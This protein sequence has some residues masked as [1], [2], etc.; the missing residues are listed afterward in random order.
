M[1]DF[2]KFLRVQWDRS[3]ATI[4]VAIGV[5]ALFLGYRGVSGTSYVAAQLPYF[6]SGGLV[7]IFFLGLGGIGW[8]SADLRD[9]WRELR[10]IRQLLE[11]GRPVPAHAEAE[12]FHDDV[13]VDEL[14]F[15]DA[16][17]PA[18]K[19][20]R[21]LKAGSANGRRATTKAEAGA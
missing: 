2:L 9:E 6:V 5:L 18:A 17:A 8:I 15:V 12:V 14:D 4:A 11:G 19:R 1:N 16:P 20:P 21:Q 10:A 13:S 7:G 3:T